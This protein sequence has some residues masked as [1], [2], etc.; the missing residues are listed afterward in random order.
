MPDARDA[1]NSG[2]EYRRAAEV[3]RRRET[4]MAD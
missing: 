4:A 2:P 1:E 3:F